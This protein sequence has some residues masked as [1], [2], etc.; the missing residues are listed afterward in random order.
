MKSD[1]KSSPCAERWWSETPKSAIFSTEQ[2]T[3]RRHRLA[4]ARDVPGR[5]SSGNCTDGDECMMVIA[6]RK[7]HRAK[8]NMFPIMI[9][10][11][12]WYGRCNPNVPAPHTTNTTII[13]LIII[14]IASIFLN[15]TEMG[16]KFRENITSSCLRAHQFCGRMEIW[17]NN[18]FLFRGKLKAYH[19]RR[20]SLDC[21]D[22]VDYVQLFRP[23]W[24]DGRRGL[25]AF[26]VSVGWPISLGGFDGAW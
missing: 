26:S 6:P 23:R 13:I 4:D 9:T 12:R 17:N 20:E 5:S 19:R 8:R 18:N 25:G 22:R 21:S 7:A 15:D 3:R 11:T 2:P 10:I 24:T 16:G 14:I 1:N